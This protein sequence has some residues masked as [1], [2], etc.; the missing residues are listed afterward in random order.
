MEWVRAKHGAAGD[1]CYRPEVCRSRRSYIRHRDRIRQ[2]RQLRYHTQTKVDQPQADLTEHLSAILV[3]HRPQGYQT[4]I[5]GL[6]VV[7]RQ[8]RTRVALVPPIYCG[9]MAPRHIYAYL[10]RLLGLLK[11]EYGLTGFQGLVQ[12]PPRNWQQSR[13]GKN[14]SLRELRLECPDLAALYSAVLVIERP[15]GP[16]LVVSAIAAEIWRGGQLEAIVPTVS[17]TGMVAMQVRDYLTKMLQVFEQ[18]YKIRKFARIDWRSPEAMP[19]VGAATGQAETTSAS[20]DPPFI[21]NLEELWHQ[22]EQ[23]I[24][25]VAA[26]EQLQLAA[27]AIEAIVDEFVDFANSTFEELNP[28]VLRQGPVLPAH[29]LDAYVR[30]TMEVDFSPFLLEAPRFPRKAPEA[31]PLD[32]EEIRSVVEE[33]EK[34]V[35]LELVAEEVEQTA[36]ETFTAAMATAHAENVSEWVDAIE[37]GL[38]QLRHGQVLLLEFYRSQRLSLIELWLGLLLGGHCLQSKGDF[39]DLEKIWILKSE[40]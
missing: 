20:T 28:V 8:G 11:Y 3:V 4:P 29:T 30:Q 34:A 36:E 24:A 26:P 17:C 25:D 9:G 21:L 1:G 27:E 2:E 15:S 33:V 5:D 32:P 12:L 40:S 23:A 38:Q 10:N 39:Y 19:V 18:T 37:Q 6:S 22:L 35:L 14:K 31:R 16:D 13:P 7:V